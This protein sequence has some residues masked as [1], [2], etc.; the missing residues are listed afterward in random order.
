VPSFLTAISAGTATAFAA[1]EGLTP[2]IQAVGMKA[3][4]NATSDAYNTVF[5]STIAFSGFGIILAFFAP[6]VDHLLS[7]DVA[8]TLHEKNTEA[9]VGSHGKGVKDMQQV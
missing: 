7:G 1:V 2:A 3:Y 5:L 9:V 8:V 6:N 4:Q